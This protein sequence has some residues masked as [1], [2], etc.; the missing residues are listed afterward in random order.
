MLAISDKGSTKASAWL[1]LRMSCFNA[2]AEFE[3][4]RATSTSGEMDDLESRYRRDKS[5]LDKGRRELEAMIDFV[6]TNTRLDSALISAHNETRALLL[7]SSIGTSIVFGTRFRHSRSPLA[8]MLIATHQLDWRLGERAIAYSRLSEDVVVSQL[9]ETLDEYSKRGKE[10]LGAVEKC[11]YALAKANATLTASNTALAGCRSQS[12]R[13]DLWQH[14]N[15]YRVAVRDRSQR[16]QSL[17]SKV[18]ECEAIFERL[19]SWRQER[20]RVAR[21]AF[22]TLSQTYRDDMCRV[23]ERLVKCGRSDFCKYDTPDLPRLPLIDE[24]REQFTERQ[25]KIDS[26]AKSKGALVFPPFVDSVAPTPFSGDDDASSAAAQIT[27]PSTEAEPPRASLVAKKGVLEFEQLLL[28]WVH[29]FCVLTFDGFFHGFP[30]RTEGAVE[31]EKALF[32]ADLATSSVSD[33]EEGPDIYIYSHSSNFLAKFKKDI[34]KLRSRD[35]ADKFAWL[36]ALADPLVLFDES[37]PS[38]VLHSNPTDSAPTQ[39]PVNPTGADVTPAVTPSPAP[40]IF[41]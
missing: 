11:R 1:A 14:E 40:S 7:E 39:A 26:G 22:G 21:E 34:I 25:A 35:A 16:Q 36:Q 29:V 17:G 3:A 30:G 15:T 31:H 10:A 28:G 13:N 19:E 6:L 12:V 33:D 18:A 37:S 23:G 9:K 32:T 20:L 38:D 5:T 4:S 8:D 24:T 2:L 41:V 27:F